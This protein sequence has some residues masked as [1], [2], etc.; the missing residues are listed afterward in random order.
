M[1]DLVRLALTCEKSR[2]KEIHS[3]VQDEHWIWGEREGIARRRSYY[4]W[5]ADAG[6]GHT[7]YWAHCG[8]KCHTECVFGL[9]KRFDSNIASVGVPR[10]T[11]TIINYYLLPDLCA[12]ANI[13]TNEWLLSL[14]YLIRIQTERVYRFL[15]NWQWDLFPLRYYSSNVNGFRFQHPI[16]TFRT[17]MRNC[18]S[19]NLLS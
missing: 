11:I 6:G 9:K 12:A 7:T 14:Q 13:R 3:C 8:I 18:D 4:D 16:S 17:K 5:A 15:S 10:P 1:C 19:I 2:R